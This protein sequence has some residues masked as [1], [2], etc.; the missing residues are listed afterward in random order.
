MD[1][2]YTYL[3]DVE[4]E[5]ERAFRAAYCEEY[6]RVYEPG[7]AGDRARLVYWSEL[8]G[9]AGRLARERVLREAAALAAGEQDEEQDQHAA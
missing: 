1:T 5:A 8:A 7:H 4:A 6:S 3:T 9:A 2:I